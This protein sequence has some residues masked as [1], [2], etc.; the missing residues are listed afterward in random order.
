MFAVIT[1]FG[2][3]AAANYLAGATYAKTKIWF[4]AGAVAIGLNGLVIALIPMMSYWAVG[5][6]TALLAAIFALPL[7]LWLGVKLTAPRQAKTPSEDTNAQPA[8]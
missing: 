7:G 6:D 2:L 3:V 1:A 5:P 4:L 8:G